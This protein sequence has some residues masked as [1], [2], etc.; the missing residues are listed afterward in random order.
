MEF[1]ERLKEY[2]EEAIEGRI[3]PG[4]VVGVVQKNGDRAV[5]PFGN[6]TYEANA[7]TVKENTIYDVASITK[8][9]PTGS[10]ALELLEEGRLKLEDKLIEYIPEFRN[11]D[12][13]RVL[14]KHLLT[15]TLDGYGLG[16]ALD[17]GDGI[18]L[19]K[20]TCEELQEV[21]FTH[22]FKKGPGEVFKYTNIPAAL[23][24]LV[25]ERITGESLDAL[26][27][28]RLFDPLKMERTT[29]YPEN[30]PREEIVPTEIDEW[31]G[32]VHGIVHDESAY[33]CR[34][35][36]K[37]VGHAGLFTT[38][39]DILNF[40]E[41]LLHEGN[42]NGKRFF[43]KETV[44]EMRTNQISHLDDE[45][46]LGWELNQP[47]FMGKYAGPHTFGKTGFTGSLCV[48][49]I[50]KGIGYII[51]SNRIYPK[52]PQNS[53]A[54]NAFRAKV[55]EIFLDPTFKSNKFT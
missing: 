5:F 11:S 4:C 33:I 21:L 1:K 19:H 16:R 39:P 2:S 13:E 32:E 3:F 44:K 47:R 48:C 45:T 10:L 37:T 18:S 38:A 12:R 22:D 23:L 55:G 7:Q 43:S 27:Q 36:G 51:L 41:M 50:E 17:G 34:K 30:F 6:F 53:E 31:R 25:I 26:A 15:Y 49:D 35:E 52:R 46:G 54:I 28:E 14:I 20:R 42:F 24:G 29:F 9:I 8:A 40:L